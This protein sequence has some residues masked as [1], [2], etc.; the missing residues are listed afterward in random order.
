M[1]MRGIIFKQIKRREI[2][3]AAKPA[4]N[5][6]TLVI[7]QFKIAPI[8]MYG[9]NIRIQRMDN[10]R[11]PAGKPFASIY[12]QLG[13]HW[14]GYCSIHHG[15]IDPAFFE[16]ISVDYYSCIATTS[17]SSFPLV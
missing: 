1:K 5:N 17:I 12:L 3:S 16:N 15:C 13:A 4:V 8:S 6:I 7:I 14:I 9:G 2:G 11:Q 10:Q